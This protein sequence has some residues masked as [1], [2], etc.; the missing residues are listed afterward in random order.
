MFAKCNKFI[1]RSHTQEL[2]QDQG[3]RQPK[4]VTLNATYQ[5]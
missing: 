1:V 5:L 2:Y 4:A 3:Q